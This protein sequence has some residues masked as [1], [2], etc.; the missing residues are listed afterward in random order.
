MIEAL[1]VGGAVASVL[2]TIL[3]G[4]LVALVVIVMSENP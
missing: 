2:A 1:I 3:L 4:A